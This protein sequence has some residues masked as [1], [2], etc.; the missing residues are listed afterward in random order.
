M[1]AKPP[2]IQNYFLT[3]HA[4]FEMVRRQVSESDVAR[5]LGAPEYTE[6]VRPGRALYQ[7][8]LSHATKTYLLRIFVD[9]DR[10]PPQ[11]VTVY[12]TSK[13][14]KYWRSE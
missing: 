5:V 3:E 9:I 14:A 4:R 10:E 1:M 12:R 8:R 2:P 7:A 11:V 13:I 6:L